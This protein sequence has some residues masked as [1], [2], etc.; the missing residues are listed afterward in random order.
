MENLVI[1]IKYIY[2][3][4]LNFVFVCVILFFCNSNYG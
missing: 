4:M 3:F 1:Y 2:I